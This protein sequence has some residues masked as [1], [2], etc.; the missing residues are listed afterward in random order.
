MFGLWPTFGFM[1]AVSKQVGIKQIFVCETFPFL[2]IIC[3]T[4][5]VGS[6]M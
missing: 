1:F 5:K 6:N 4:K 2:I 3:F